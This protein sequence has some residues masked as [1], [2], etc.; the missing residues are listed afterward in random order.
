MHLSFIGMT[1][2]RMNEEALMD[3]LDLDL[4]LEITKKNQRIGVNSIIGHTH[5]DK[6]R[7]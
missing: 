7:V 3:R 6:F 4:D 1:T 5:L 2:K